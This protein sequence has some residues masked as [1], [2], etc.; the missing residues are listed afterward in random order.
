MSSSLYLLFFQTS[1]LPTQQKLYVI[2]LEGG[3]DHEWSL[4]LS[5]LMPPLPATT[6]NA[7]FRDRW[8]D[9]LYEIVRLRTT[10]VA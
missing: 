9:E 7:P 3:L 8:H 10:E 4:W 2:D 6:V 5:K 1:K